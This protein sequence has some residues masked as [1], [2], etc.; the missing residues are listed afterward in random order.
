VCWQSKIS[1]QLKKYASFGII[2]K[3]LLAPVAFLIL[4]GFL[5]AKP[6]VQFRLYRMVDSR[7]GHLGANTELV[8]LATFDRNRTTSKKEILVYCSESWNSSNNFLRTLFFRDSIYIRGSLAWLCL[9]LATQISIFK[10]FATVPNR[11]LLID[12]MGYFSMNLPKLKFTS[13]ENFLGNK[14]VSEHCGDFTKYVCLSVR[15]S[16]YLT[17]IYG[18]ELSKHDH[19][20]SKIDSYIDASTTL[21]NFGFT[22]F[23]MGAIVNQ[24]FKCS[25]PRLIDYATNGMRNEFL[26]VYLGANCTFAVT[27]DTGI[28]SVP[29]IFGRPLLYVNILPVF[30][31]WIVTLNTVIYPKVITDE[32]KSIVY[33][34]K[35]LIDQEIVTRQKSEAYKDAGVEIR[36]LSSEELVE[37]VT[38][39]AQ[40]VEGTFVETPEQKEMQAKLK[41]ILSTHPKLQP[42]PNYY[43]IRAQFAS[44]FLSRYP[45]FLDGLD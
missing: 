13:K 27:T 33:G 5:I 1:F 16:S 32:S 18:Q 36:D 12:R 44:C 43:P 2:P 24:K 11:D 9:R 15:D 41:H 21:A 14:F 6:F 17:A 37:A 7:M 26:D 38:E 29:K 10:S 25:N 35:D 45:N 31:S 42:S 30:A 40:R 19:R 22:V 3:L 4:C 28:D 23:R 34:L 8:R 20:D 39:M